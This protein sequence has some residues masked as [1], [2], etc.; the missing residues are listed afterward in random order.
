MA[1][2]FDYIDEAAVILINEPSKTAERAKNYTWQL[3]EDSRTL[4]EAGILESSLLRFA[5]GWEEL[6]DRASDFP[7]VMADSF[8]AAKY[9][10][11]PR[12][13]VSISA[14][15][16]PS[17]GGSLETAAGDIAHYVGSG[18]STVVLCLDERRAG[19]LEAYLK[20]A[21]AVLPI[22]PHEAARNGQCVIALVALSAGMEYPR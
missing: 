3:E 2:A 18:Y 5:V 16:L 22:R 13:L 14:K 4:L 21:D 19:I 15:Q 11:T 12:E 17:Y 6:C 8:L 1:T 7:V 20:N 10:L 9:P